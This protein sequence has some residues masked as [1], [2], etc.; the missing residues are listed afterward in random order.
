[1]SPRLGIMD[2]LTRAGLAD[3]HISPKES[4][5]VSILIRLNHMNLQI[6]T[7]L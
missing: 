7:C 1:M 3:L 6:F 4:N 5:N 2:R